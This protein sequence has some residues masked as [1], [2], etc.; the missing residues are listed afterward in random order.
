METL[1]VGAGDISFEVLIVDNAPTDKT[2]LLLERLRNAKIIGN[3]TNHGFGGGCN[4]AVN[5]AVGKYLLLLNNDT[6]LMRTLLSIMVDTFDNGVDVGAVG[7]KLIFP[8]GRLQEAGSIIWR[9][10]SCQ[11]Y[12]R[13]EDPFKPEFSYVKDVDFCSGA[14][15]LTPRELFL[16]L[17][18][19]DSRY[20][21]AYYED[22]DYCIQIWD[23][24]Y[25][26]VF[27]PFSIAIH[28][29]FGSSKSGDA[30]ALQI[31]NREKFLKKWKASLEFYGF[32]D[33]DKIVFSRDIKLIQN[34]YCSLTT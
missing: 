4:Q 15:L 25:R 3:S 20:A 33:P 32:F 5:L 18:G 13:F 21:P 28:H 11:G 7:G 8:D 29:E 6:R 17:G 14:L 31:K 27:Q 2:P 9:D 16:S 19:F 12:G 24:G 10:G 26:V 34:E 23:R 1:A 22:V 30:I